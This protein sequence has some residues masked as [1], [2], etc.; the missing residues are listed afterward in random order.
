MDDIAR[1]CRMTKPTLYECFSS[2]A[3]LFDALIQRERDALVTS[4]EKLLVK[5]GRSGGPSLTVLAYM[6]TSGSLGA[7]LASRHLLP[8]H[9]DEVIDLATGFI[10][11]AFRHMPTEAINAFDQVG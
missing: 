3:E 2:K 8:D 7:V 6:A 9:A 4:M 1:R 11:A 5:H 10:D